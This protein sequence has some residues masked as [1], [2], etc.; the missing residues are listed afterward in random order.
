[1]A[2]LVDLPAGRQART[3]L[4]YMFTVYVLCSLAREYWY[5]GLTNNLER[6]VLQHQQGRERTTRSYRPFILIHT[7]QFASRPEARNREKW[8]KSGIG[9]EWLKSSVTPSDN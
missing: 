4:P 7:E 3:L 1:M 5:V 8:L 6:R 2:E 9:K